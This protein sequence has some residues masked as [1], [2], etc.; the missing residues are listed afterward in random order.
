MK[1]YLGGCSFMENP[2]IF[3]NNLL[4]NYIGNNSIIINNAKS[5]SSNDQIFRKALFSILKTNFD[6]VLIGWTQCWRI[7]KV[8]EVYEEDNDYKNILLEESLNNILSGSK[9]Y[10]EV[11]ANDKHY[12]RYCHLEPEGTDFVIMY[13]II[14]QQILKSKNI[15]HLFLS[16]GE[17]MP[18][19][20]NARQG[21][22]PLIDEKYYFGE[23]TLQQKMSYPLT[24]HFYNE[25]MKIFG[26]NT[27]I[28]WTDERGL[29]RDNANHL[30]KNGGRVLSEMVLKY[31]QENKIL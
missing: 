31:I 2:N 8:I 26:E 1:V 22:L 13:T 7:D 30:S 23:G 19:T 27:G 9:Y 16:M 12:N 28:T 11:V 24:T 3:E 21:W 17:V 6:F 5:G 18:Y 14:L 10:T 15:P 25:H 20:L 4:L 29:I